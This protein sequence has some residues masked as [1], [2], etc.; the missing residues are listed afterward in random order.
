MHQ[1]ASSRSTSNFPM[2]L[3]LFPLGGEEWCLC[4]G[5]RSSTRTTRRA[6]GAQGAL[7]QPRHGG[8]GEMGRLRGRHRD[9][10]RRL[11][12]SR[13][14][15]RRGNPRGTTAAA[16]VWR[17]TSRTSS[18]TLNYMADLGGILEGTRGKPESASS[19]RGWTPGVRSVSSAASAEGVAPQPRGSR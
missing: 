6:P 18:R 17:R 5:K 14:H 19:A 10:L 4:G 11:L 12:L 8:R 1:N 7:A 3:V 16:G 15:C 2:G 9:R 13:G